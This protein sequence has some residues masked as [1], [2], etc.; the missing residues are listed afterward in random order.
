MK[1]TEGNN[2]LYS[3]V[4]QCAWVL[5]DAPLDQVRV[6]DQING[7]DPIWLVHA[8]WAFSQP[9]MFS[10]LLFPSLPS[11]CLH[12]PASFYLFFLI[13]LHFIFFYFS[14]HFYL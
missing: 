10:F 8:F 13:F 6:I 9:N 12:P 2:Y 11:Y 1:K 4:I 3:S 5:C 14:F 7:P